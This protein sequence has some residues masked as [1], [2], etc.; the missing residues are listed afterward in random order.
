LYRHIYK[1]NFWSDFSN[2]IKF[3]IKEF[4]RRSF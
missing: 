3:L 1:I 2:P 4:G